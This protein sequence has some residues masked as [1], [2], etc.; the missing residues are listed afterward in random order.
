MERSETL[1]RRILHLK[2]NE[3]F[4][5]TSQIYYS[6]G[7]EWKKL[8]RKAL[9]LS[10]IIAVDNGQDKSVPNLNRPLFVEGSIHTSLKKKK[11]IIT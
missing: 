1:I 6:P 3:M 2:T 7:H 11:I 9:A 10:K 4:L 8:F 5:N